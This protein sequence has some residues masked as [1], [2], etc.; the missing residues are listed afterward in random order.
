MGLGFLDAVKKRIKGD[1]TPEK[2]GAS[3]ELEEAKREE[4]SSQMKVDDKLLEPPSETNLVLTGNHEALRTEEIPNELSTIYRPE[5]VPPEVL[6]LLWFKDGPLCNYSQEAEHQ[7][8]IEIEGLI[9]RISFLGAI[10]PSAIGIGDAIRCPYSPDKIE[11]PPYFP[12]YERLSPEQRWIYLNWLRNIDAEVNIGYVF[13]FYYGLERHLFFGDYMAAFDMIVRLRKV[14]KNGS[15]AGYSSSAVIAACLFRN[16]PDLFIRFLNGLEEIKDEDVNSLYLL[17][18]RALGL[19]LDSSEIMLLAQEVGFSNRR[20][21]DGEKEMFRSE[22]EKVIFRTLGKKTL[23]LM[24]FSLME[25][26]LQN[27]MIIANFSI[28]PEQRTLSIPNLCQNRAFREIVN[29]LLQ[30]THDEVKLQLKER[31]KERVSSGSEQ[32]ND[33][34]DQQTLIPCPYCGAHTKAPSSKR[35]CQACK[36]PILARVNP[37]TKEKAFVTEDDAKRFD[38]RKKDLQVIRFAVKCM[39]PFGMTN[40]QIAR[41]YQELRKE[42]DCTVNEAVWKIANEKM[43]TWT[44][45]GVIPSQYCYLAIANFLEFE[46]KDKSE[47]M[48]KF[49]EEDKKAM[50]RD[51]DQRLKYMRDHA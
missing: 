44:E 32:T 20:Y 17:A 21:L 28:R 22:L 35:I 37:D 45:E 42:R 29:D 18:K 24:S 5:A 14:H 36:K 40:E 3:Q 19:D 39:W 50:E 27:V 47:M 43:R 12:S 16:R 30:K 41:T 34:A 1:Q 10:E 31:R 15:F 9:F 46:G 49:Q 23:N 6:R 38:A 11:R 33:I 7:E 2:N 25:S 51:M 13:I 48:D 26:P 8:S 4:K